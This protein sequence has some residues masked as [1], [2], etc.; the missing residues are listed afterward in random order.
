MRRWV[1]DL[2]PAQW[3]VVLGALAFGVGGGATLVDKVG[4]P[5]WLF[6]GLLATGVLMGLALGVLKF[7]EV[8]EQ[9]RSAERGRRA[10][11]EARFESPAR[12]VWGPE[13][14]GDYFAGRERVLHEIVG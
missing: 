11:V 14:R 13:E 3:T 6:F 10:R 9:P 5:K 8:S 1:R 7:I 4:G 12:A 2:R